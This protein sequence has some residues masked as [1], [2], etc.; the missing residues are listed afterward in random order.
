[1]HRSDSPGQVSRYK[2]RHSQKHIQLST[3]AMNHQAMSLYNDAAPSL[4]G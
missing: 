2:L 4:T 1:M 3:E